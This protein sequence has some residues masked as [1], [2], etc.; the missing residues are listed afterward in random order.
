MLIKVLQRY[1]DR[2]ISNFNWIVL[3]AELYVASLIEQTYKA[4]FFSIGIVSVIIAGSFNDEK[5]YIYGAIAF[6]FATAVVPVGIALKTII[7]S[8]HATD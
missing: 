7:R 6:W 2:E 8:R 4:R 1:Q 5:A 3:V